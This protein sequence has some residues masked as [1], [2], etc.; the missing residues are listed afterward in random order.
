MT[1]SEVLANC[2]LGANL[3]RMSSPDTL[4]SETRLPEVDG[5]RGCAILLV[6]I[7]H[8]V[9]ADLHQGFITPA[10]YYSLWIFQLGW[11]G[12]DLFFVLSGFL[13]GGILL[14]FRDSSNM[15]KTFYI[16]RAC[17]ILP[18]CILFVLGFI[19]GVYLRDNRVRV[20]YVILFEKHGP[21]WPYL[22]FV[23]NYW[24]ALNH[25]WS[26][27]FGVM[28]WS[29]AIEE[30]FYLVIPLVTLVLPRRTLPFVLVFLIVATVG[31]R[32]SMLG[33]DSHM[34]VYL[35]TH[36]RLDGLC[37]GFLL[38]WALRQPGVWGRLRQMRLPLYGFT[39]VMIGLVVWIGIED[40]GQ[41]T[42]LMPQYGYL[43]LAVFYATLVLVG[44]TFTD[45]IFAKVLRWRPLRFIGKIS[46]SLY[47][48]HQSINFMVSAYLCNRKPGLY[49][50]SD[51]VFPL[52]ALAISIAVA[53]LTLKTIE[54]PMIRF[55][56]GF[57]YETRGEIDRIPAPPAV[58]GV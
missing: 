11:S 43:I 19:L 5:L 34:Q 10:L 52:L 14:D 18:L 40:P 16:R 57:K 3:A 35:M 37:M 46:Y 13:I 53:Y 28:T 27:V 26:C 4:S 2:A 36:T 38:A 49:Q 58:P 50:G 55:G 20:N 56:H 33:P 45:S 30:H 22:L 6:I 15:L 47:L 23:Q 29:L 42:D 39:A 7:F 24:M 12:V 17:R 31:M 9:I 44:V 1:A 54:S 32:W 48:T 8:F 21:I 51:L 25:S 41:A